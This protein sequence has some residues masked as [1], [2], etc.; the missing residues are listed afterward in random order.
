[1][2]AKKS[3]LRSR[4]DACIVVRFSNHHNHKAIGKKRA[5]GGTEITFETAVDFES[6][7]QGKNFRLNTVLN[8][9]FG[10]LSR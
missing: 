4:R 10:T 5:I 8:V 3:F 6:S 7:L 1:M 9:A 2:N